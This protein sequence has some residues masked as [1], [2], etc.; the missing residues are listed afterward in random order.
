VACLRPALLVRP[1]NPRGIR[2][3]NDLARPGLKI[4]IGDPRYSTCGE[5]FV[6]LLE[7]KGLREKVMANVALPARTH[8]EI[9]KGLILG[10]LDAV[11]VWDFA[12]ALQKDRL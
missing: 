7:Q 11:V 3:I 10:P 5:M 12:A 1:G 6:Q 8:A 9:A 2:S 4:G